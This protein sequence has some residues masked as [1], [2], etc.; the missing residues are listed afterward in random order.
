MNTEYL[1]LISYFEEHKSYVSRIK[2]L[3]DYFPALLD[4]LDLKQF[5]K[6]LYNIVYAVKSPPICQTCQ[7]NEATFISFD[8]GYRPYCCH[9]CAVANVNTIKKRKITNKVKYGNENVL[10]NTVVK[11]KKDDT[12]I[13]R[14]GVIHALQNIQLK[15]KSLKKWENKTEEELLVKKQKTADTI[16]EKYGTNNIFSI[17]EIENKRKQTNLER[18]GVEFALQSKQIIEEGKNTKR[19]NFFDSLSE[20]VPSAIPMFKEFEGIN[21]DTKPIV[22]EW[23]CIKCDTVYSD[24]LDD[25]DVPRCPTCWPI[26]NVSSVGQREVLAFL[27]ELGLSTMEG[28]RTIIAPKELDIVLPDQKI[29]IEYCGV[30][31]HSELRVVNNYQQDKAIK[32]QKQGLRLITI[33]EDEWFQKQEICKHILKSISTSENRLLDSSKIQIKNIDLITAKFFL[34]RYNIF[35]YLTSTYAIGAYFQDQLVSVMTFDSVSDNRY[36]LIQV[37]HS[38]KI[39]DI[40]ER[41]LDNFI[42]DFNPSTITSVC[43]LRWNDP[44][45]YE[46]MNFIYKDISEPD[47]CLSNDGLS[48]YNKIDL[49]EIQLSTY[50]R[51]YDCG[52]ALY[53]WKKE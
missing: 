4:K 43:D 6:S 42:Q 50:Y 10:N 41:L 49:T 9:H 51:I 31:W 36:E 18:F 28:N 22:Y 14:Y 46:K 39:K 3:K 38:I 5:A 33:F 32:C 2:Y 15:E 11:K 20:R 12:M 34:E 27:K 52:S 13:K 25:G 29:A 37:A 21:R 47:Y 24:H 23:K 44:T 8:D 35:G 48:R 26:T 30:Y 53:E 45:L 16:L 7:I 1:N 40:E 19:K 17:S